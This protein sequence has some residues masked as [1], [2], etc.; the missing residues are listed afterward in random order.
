MRL[1]DTSIVRITKPIITSFKKA[2]ANERQAV[3]AAGGAPSVLTAA[4]V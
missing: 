3:T 4:E 1:R 2:G